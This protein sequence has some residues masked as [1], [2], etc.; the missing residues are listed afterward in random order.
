MTTFDYPRGVVFHDLQSA[1][2]LYSTIPIPAYTSRDLIHIEPRVETWKEI[3][4]TSATDSVA[5]DYYNNMDTKDVAAIIAHE[6][7]HH[8]DF[9]HD[10]FEGDEENMWFEEGMCEYLSKK[11]LLSETKFQAIQNVE[12]KL[13]KNYKEIYGEYT[14]DRFG[15]SGYRSGKSETFSAAFYDYWRSSKTVTRLVHEHFDG[16]IQALIACYVQWEQNEPVHKYF[17]RALSLTDD[18]AREMWLA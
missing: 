16:D 4:L 10:D 17:I 5:I 6:L 12:D 15:E 1:T 18:E 14:L 11:L 9:F 7:T 8:A 2:E 13:I 3:F